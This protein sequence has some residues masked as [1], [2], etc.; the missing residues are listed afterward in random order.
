MGKAENEEISNS[1]PRINGLA[2]DDID[3]LKHSI[4]NSGHGQYR[5]NSSL[6]T[7]V[8]KTLKEID[9]IFEGKLLLQGMKGDKDG[10]VFD[11]VAKD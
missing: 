1:A 8:A 4:K 9:K 2:V 10:A 3:Q 5:T 6:A 11:F 7:D